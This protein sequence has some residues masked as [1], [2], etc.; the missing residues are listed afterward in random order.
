[1]RIV[2]T[3]ATGFIGQNFIPM[4]VENEP[5]VEI[6]T[7]N[8]S[9]EKAE[10]LFPQKQCRHISVEE[11]A[12]IVDFKPDMVFHLA[13]LSTSR[14]DWDIIEPMMSANLTF[15]VQLLH[16]VSQCPDLKLF[17]N[18]GTFAQYR[19]GTQQICDAY[20]YSATKTAFRQFVEYYS[21]LY[22]FKYV[23]LVP[24][25]IYGGKDT[26]KKLID[27]I[28]EATTSDTPVDMTLGEQVLD[29]THVE[30]VAGF[31]LHLIRNLDLF[32]GIR[33]GE[34]FHIGTGRGTSPRELAAIVE[35]E[36][37]KKCNINWGGRPYR[38]MDTM[39]AVAPIAKNLEL[40][41]WRAKVSVEEGVRRMKERTNTL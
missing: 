10:K 41:K 24:Y 9:V 35:R 31:F 8:R 14:N 1:M 29:F 20:L 27:Y 37:G 21:Q 15:G 12:Q 28:I 38:P 23:Q 25:T 17:V 18:I 34:E 11:M 5:S 40:L 19:L 2:I 6:M 30:D 13:T 39:Y 7:L 26:A 33:N 22:S 3:G 32:A 4:L 16:Y 36:F